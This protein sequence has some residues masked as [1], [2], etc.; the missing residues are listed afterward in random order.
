MGRYTCKCLCV[1]ECAHKGQKGLPDDLLYLSAYSFD[2]KFLPETR[3]NVSLGWKPASP[4]NP[5]MS[6]YCGVG[7]TGMCKTPNLLFG[8]LIL[9][10]V[11]EQQT[12]LTAEPPLLPMFKLSLMSKRC[13]IF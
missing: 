7:A 9:V 10:P 13:V 1:Y 11:I 6:T 12:L 8:I 3:D 2:I 5:T 4:R